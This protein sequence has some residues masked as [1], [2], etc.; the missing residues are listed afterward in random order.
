MASIAVRDTARRVARVRRPT[1]HT[2]DRGGGEQRAVS[3]RA[4][5]GRVR[6][7]AWGT[8]MPGLESGGGGGDGH[9]RDGLIWGD[10]G[11]FAAG[12]APGRRSRGRRLGGGPVP[13][14]RHGATRAEAREADRIVTLLTRRT[15][16]PR[17][18][19]GRP[20]HP[21]AVGR[22]AGAVRPRRRAVLRRPDLDVITQAQTWTR[23]APASSGT[24]RYTAGCAVLETAT[25]SSPRKASRRCGC[26]CW[27]SA[28]PGARRPRARRVAG[29]DAFLLRAM[30]PAGWAPASRT[31]RAAPSPARAAR[32]AF[33][34]GISVP[35]V[36]P[37]RLGHPGPE[38]RLLDALL[39]GDWT[40][41]DATARRPGARQRAGGRAPAVAPRAPAPVAAAGGAAGAG[42]RYGPV[43]WVRSRRRACRRPDR[44]TGGRREDHPRPAPCFVVA[45]TTPEVP[46]ASP[47]ARTAGWTPRSPRSP[48]PGHSAQDSTRA[49]GPGLAG[50]SILLSSAITPGNRRVRPPATGHRRRRIDSRD[51][52]QRPP[53]PRSREPRAR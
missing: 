50:R 25:G 9:H 5:G 1:A 36:P 42:H 12:G 2:G 8:G 14:H 15:A 40:V 49:R 4:C 27:S 35:A 47:S 17:R 44:H 10:L 39:H 30:T 52:R 7:R 37:A 31:A 34:W 24:T 6:W 45:G 22:P 19:E 32:S 16:S 43:R 21:V 3:A 53:P 38:I 46:A 23:S 29:P 48:E 13:R 28:D 41:A 20:A 11:R 33:R 26:T 51:E 18:R